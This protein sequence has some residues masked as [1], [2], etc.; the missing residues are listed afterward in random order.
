MSSKIVFPNKDQ[1]RSY[2]A[3]PKRA[4]FGSGHVTEERDFFVP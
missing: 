3:W 2:L 4:N 1:R